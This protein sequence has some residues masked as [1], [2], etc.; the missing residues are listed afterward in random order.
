VKSKS[1]L[2]ALGAVVALQNAAPWKVQAAEE[3]SKPVLFYSRYYNA[4]WEDRY[5]PDGTFKRV[6]QR[7]R[8]DFDVRVHNQPLAPGTLAEVKV[9]F[10]ANP[11]DKAVGNHPAPPHVS[12]A[13]IN[14]LTE[15]VK[16]GGR[17]IVTGNQENHNLEI[18]DM[19]KLL[20]QFGMQFT[21]RYTEAKNLCCHNR[22]Q[23]SAAF[24]GLIT[25]ATCCCSIPRSRPD[26]ERW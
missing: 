18:E 26:P 23:S 20:A 15:F 17:L 12:S 25:P 4:E 21:S 8:G 19:N 1:F 16:N 6:I 22:R 13:D 14:V 5:L 10:I 2:L 3:K 11:S 24:A 9:L 7:L